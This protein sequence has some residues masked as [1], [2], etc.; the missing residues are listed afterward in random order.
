MKKRAYTKPRLQRLGLL[1]LRTSV[2]G[3]GGSWHWCW[4]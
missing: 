1:R 3:S 4:W 2:S